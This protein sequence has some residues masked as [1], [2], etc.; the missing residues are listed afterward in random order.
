MRFP[1][2]RARCSLKTIA[3]IF[4]LALSL[5]DRPHP[6]GRIDAR[7]QWE[8]KMLSNFG[9]GGKTCCADLSVNFIVVFPADASVCT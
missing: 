7:L 5:R 1:S 9:L 4:M 3:C 2:F 6:G 8:L